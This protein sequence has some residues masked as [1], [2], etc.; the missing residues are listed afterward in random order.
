MKF[1]NYRIVKEFGK[2]YIEIPYF[3]FWW[4]RLT[5]FKWVNMG[6]R[7]IRVKEE[8]KFDTYDEAKDFAEKHM[9]MK[10]LPKG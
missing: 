6:T 8:Y 1:T 5:Y 4:K 10:F 9:Y 7:S 2:Y 3:H